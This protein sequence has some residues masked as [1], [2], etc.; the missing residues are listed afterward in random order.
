MHPDLPVGSEPCGTLSAG[1]GFDAV[2]IVPVD[3]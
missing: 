3:H 2:S 1:F